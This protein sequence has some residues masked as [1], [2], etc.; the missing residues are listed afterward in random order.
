VRR[1]GSYRTDPRR[2]TCKLQACSNPIIHRKSCFINRDGFTLIELLVVIAIIALLLAIF[3]PVMRAARERAQRAVCLSNL[4][5]LTT[6][7]IAYA[8]DHEGKLASGS[9]FTTRTGLDNKGRIR[10]LEPWVGTAFHFP[11]TRSALL[12]NPDK[13]VL[14]PYL[15][16]VDLYRCPGAWP[17]HA[18]SYE[19]VSAANGGVQ[20]PG[21][22]LP[23]S[24]GWELAELGVRVRDT[25]L[26]LTRLT[27][28]RSPGPSARAVFVDR[29]HTPADSG[30]Y[31]YYLEPKWYR[32]SPPPIHHGN[33]AT[34]SAAD[35]HAE[36]WSWSGRETTAGLPRN[37]V[38]GLRGQHIEILRGGDFSPKTDDG[39]HDLQRLQR[40]TWGRLGY[41]APMSQ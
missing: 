33:G 37:R 7:W 16:T 3:L 34:L 6:A 20:V 40:T 24:A 14:W 11:E 26:R 38:P 12:A 21:T 15:R 30:F 8:D 1:G 41:A 4:R 18:L 10:K 28:I 35:G 2:G 36:Y 5:Q 32:N 29:G 23:G 13:G 22:Y 25:V 31:V 19:A 17:G 39:L 9:A 27:D